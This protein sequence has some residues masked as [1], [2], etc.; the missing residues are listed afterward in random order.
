[1]RA[2]SGFLPV[3]NHSL[4][5]IMKIPTM[6]I[7]FATGSGPKHGPADVV[8]S[9]IHVHTYSVEGGRGGGLKIGT[10]SPAPHTLLW[11]KLCIK[12]AIKKDYYPAD[13]P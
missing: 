2:K 13:P 7:G 8:I 6:V 3:L 9:F 12:N 11:G 10:P 4:K 5:P 1:M